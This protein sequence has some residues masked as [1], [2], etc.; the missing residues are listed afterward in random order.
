VA[1]RGEKITALFIN[2]IVYGM[3]GGKM[4]LTTII[5]QN[6]TTIPGVRIYSPLPMISRGY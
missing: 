3:T 1:N 5:G 2:N 4:A 6:T